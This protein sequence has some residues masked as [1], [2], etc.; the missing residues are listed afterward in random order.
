MYSPSSF[1]IR[2]SMSPSISSFELGSR[3]QG[4]LNSCP[5]TSSLGNVSRGIKSIL[6]GR[7]FVAC[8][9]LF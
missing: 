6:Q 1:E 2:G 8:V 7:V 3:D 9:D 5:L 4:T